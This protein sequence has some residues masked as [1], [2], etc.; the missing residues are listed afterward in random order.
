[1]KWDG[2]MAG[3]DHYELQMTNEEFRNPPSKIRNR[4]TGDWQQ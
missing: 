1:M 4:Q 2:G 3:R